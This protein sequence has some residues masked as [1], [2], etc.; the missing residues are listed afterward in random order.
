[1]CKRKEKNKI[2]NVNNIK[3]SHSLDDELVMKLQSEGI[4]FRSHP[5]SLMSVNFMHYNHHFSG[6]GIRNVH[7]GIEFCNKDKLEDQLSLVKTGFILILH[8]PRCRTAS[9]CLFSSIMDYLSY[10]YLTQHFILELPQ[11]SDCLII[12]DVSNYVESILETDIY[13]QVHCFLPTSD[14]GQTMYATLKSRNDRK[15]VDYSD[16]YSKH[17]SLLGYTNSLR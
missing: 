7:G 2:I 5:R 13:E 12:G 11:Y 3:F 10:V 8:A 4:V 1:M 9:L 16:F 14:V 6:I 17:I 15:F